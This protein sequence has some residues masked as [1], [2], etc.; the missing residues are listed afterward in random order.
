MPFKKL[1]NWDEPYDPGDEEDLHEC[2]VRNDS[3]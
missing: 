1:V 3:Q 2:G